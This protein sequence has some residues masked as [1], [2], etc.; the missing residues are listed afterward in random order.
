MNSRGARKTC[1]AI[2]NEEAEGSP[3]DTRRVLARIANRI[4]AEVYADLVAEFR[5]LANRSASGQSVAREL[6]AICKALE[7]GK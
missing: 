6:L 7:T 3:I 1:L 5:K 2:V 4:R